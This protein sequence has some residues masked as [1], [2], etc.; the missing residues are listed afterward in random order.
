MLQ[1]NTFSLLY[2]AAELNTIISYMKHSKLHEYII[3]VEVMRADPDMDTGE[4]FFFI[5]YQ[6][7]EPKPLNAVM[8]I[9][10]DFTFAANDFIKTI[11]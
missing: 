7:S 4:E 5:K 2:S 8:Q 3:G 11:K 10:S 6:L 1:T 9:I